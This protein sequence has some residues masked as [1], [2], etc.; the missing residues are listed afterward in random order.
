MPPTRQCRAL[1]ELLFQSAPRYVMA[2]DL[3]E[4]ARPANMSSSVA[5]VY[6]TLNLF[7][8]GG[9]LRRLAASGFRSF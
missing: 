8:G 4:E 7:T 3:Q 2:E 9:L 6:N 1:C 5:I